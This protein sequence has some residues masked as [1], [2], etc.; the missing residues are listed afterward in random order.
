M[1]TVAASL[2]P[3]DSTVAEAKVHRFFDHARD[4]VLSQLDQ[5]EEALASE[6]VARHTVAFG[7]GVV[8][9]ARY[10]LRRFE[11]PIKDFA[12]RGTV[13]V[14]GILLRSLQGMTGI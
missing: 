14:S 9:V 8:D 13:I 5:A 6:D 4:F 2:V 12:K 7:E 10:A 3:H 1:E 11:A